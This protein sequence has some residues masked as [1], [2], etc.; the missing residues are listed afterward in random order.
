VAFGFVVLGVS[1]TAFAF[2]GLQTTTRLIATVEQL[3]ALVEAMNTAAARAPPAACVPSPTLTPATP[4]DAACEPS[5]AVTPATPDWPMDLG[6]MKLDATTFL[7]RRRVIDGAVQHLAN[8]MR[9]IRIVPDS[10]NGR[11]GGLRLFGVRPDSLLGYLGFE[12]GDRV[13]SING[14]AI[15]TPENALAAYGRLHTS[16]EVSVVVTRRASR[17]RLEYYL[18]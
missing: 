11:L 4:P 12:N 6:V 13:D 3:E 2:V 14:I 15:T 10:E 17:M 5:P 8:P 9:L 1:S 18:N 16:N 7:V